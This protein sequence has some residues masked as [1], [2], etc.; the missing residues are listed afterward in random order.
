MYVTFLYTL[1]N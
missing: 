1:E